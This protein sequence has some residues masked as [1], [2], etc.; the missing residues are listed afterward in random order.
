MQTGD[1]GRVGEAYQQY[2]DGIRG[3]IRHQLVFEVIA[4]LLPPGGDVLD[5]GLW[6]R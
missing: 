4:D 5:M 1:F 2:S 3:R 6:R